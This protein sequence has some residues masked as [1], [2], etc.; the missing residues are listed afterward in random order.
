MTKTLLII[1]SGPPCAG[2]MTLA[3]RIAKE[4]QLPLIAKDDIKE[5]L[6]DRL[7]WKDREWSKLLGRAGYDLMFYFVESQLA[8]GRSHI[9][10]SNFSEMAAQTF[11]ELKSKYYFEPF[12]IQCRTAGRVLF[13]RFKER[14]KSGSRHPGHVDHLN[15][16]EMQEALLKGKHEAMDI[17]GQVLEVDTTDFGAIDYATLFQA[18]RSALNSVDAS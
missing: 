4:F 14:S 11:L 3:R 12:Q 2:K 15:Y 5:S 10:E 7:G 16:D 9:V 1:I 8:A 18:I 6:F 13:Q 17:G